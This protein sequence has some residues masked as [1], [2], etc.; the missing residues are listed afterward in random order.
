MERREGS[1][2]LML[3]VINV[4]PD[5]LRLSILVSALILSAKNRRSYLI[6]NYPIKMDAKNYL[7][8][9]HSHLAPWSQL[10]SSMRA[11]A[12]VWRFAETNGNAYAREYADKRK[13]VPN[14]ARDSKWLLGK[15]GIKLRL[16]WFALRDETRLELMANTPDTVIGACTSGIVDE[17]TTRTTTTATARSLHARSSQAKR[18]SDT[19]ANEQLKKQRH[20]KTNSSSGVSDDLPRFRQLQVSRIK[21][22]DVVV[23]ES[24]MLLQIAYDTG[25][26]S[27]LIES[28]LAIVESSIY[29]A[30]FADNPASVAKAFEA[31]AERVAWIS[32]DIT[33]MARFEP[34][35]FDEDAPSPAFAAARIEKARALYQPTRREPQPS[36]SNH[37]RLLQNIRTSNY[38]RD[39][40][41][42]PFCKD[43]HLPFLRDLNYIKQSTP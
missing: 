18:A 23:K 6:I 38:A 3:G 5:P 42:N 13:R 10:H 22:H 9:S 39:F 29:L 35:P 32:A 27:G 31:V 14:D 30:R 1:E 16:A 41:A 28:T 4:M 43:R 26:M 34:V 20:E 25:N 15:G 2:H 36:S 12:A 40:S 33:A 8:L 11:H 7:K 17:R 37:E 21:Y 24:R 19:T